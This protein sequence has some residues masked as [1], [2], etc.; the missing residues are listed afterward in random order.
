MRILALDIGTRTIGVAVSD[1]FGWTAQPLTTIKRKN[2]DSDFAEIGKIISEYT[3]GEIIFGLPRA[4][5]NTPVKSFLD[6]AEKLSF[7]KIPVISWDET[8]TSRRAES[9]MLEGDLSRKKRKKK[10]NQIAASLILKSYLDA[11]R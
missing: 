11:R 10:I 6:F 2:D 5:D 7:F 1:E 3:I 9:A 4:K 8:M